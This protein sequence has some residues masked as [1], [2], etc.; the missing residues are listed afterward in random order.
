MLRVIQSGTDL[1]CEES[2]TYVFLYN[3]AGAIAYYSG[4]D[5]EEAK[6]LEAK[7]R[8]TDDYWAAF[9]GPGGW[10]CDDPSDSAFPPNPGCANIDFCNE[11]FKQKWID[12]H[13][14]LKLMEGKQCTQ[15]A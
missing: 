4:I 10:I 7:A 8:D 15:S 9:L 12:T 11:N 3:E 6:A 2:G 1:Y 14:V 13:D 5:V